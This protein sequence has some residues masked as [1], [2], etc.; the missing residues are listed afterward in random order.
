[1][2]VPSEGLQKPKTIESTQRKLFI[3]DEVQ[4]ELASYR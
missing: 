3:A 1:M 4:T 2:Y